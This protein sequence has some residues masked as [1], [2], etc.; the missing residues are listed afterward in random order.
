MALQ[1]LFGVLR[2]LWAAFVL[3]GALVA[4]GGGGGGGG[5]PP[6]ND[7]PPSGGA[8]LTLSVAV[9]GQGSVSS[10]TSGISCP[11]TCNAEFAQGSTVQLTATAAANQRF[12]GWG[13]ACSGTQSTCAVL[14]S[15]AR[16]V[17]AAFAPNDSSSFALNVSVSGQGSVASQP[18]GINCGATCS[19]LFAANTQVTLTATPASGQVFSAWTG[20]CAGSGAVCTLSLSADRVASAVFVA[21]AAVGWGPQTLVSQPGVGGLGTNRTAM[22][23]DG[24]AMTTW[25]ESVIVQNAVVDRALWFSRYTPGSGWTAP[26]EVTRL[27]INFDDNPAFALSAN[28]EAIY[29]WRHFLPT[30]VP[31]SVFAV[32]YSPSTGWS[33]TRTV[34]SIDSP[35]FELKAGLDDSGRGFVMWSQFQLAPKQFELGIWA[36]R[37]GNGSWGTAQLLNTTNPAADAVVN[38]AVMPGGD[39]LGVWNGSGAAGSGYQSAFFSQGS[40]SWGEPVRIVPNTSTDTIFI[41]PNRPGLAASEAGAVLAWA[42]GDLEGSGLPIIYRSQILSLRFSNGAWATTP[43]P[44]SNP[45]VKSLSGQEASNINT[46]RPSVSINA[47]GVAAVG[48]RSWEDN[49]NAVWVNRS[50]AGGSWQTPQTI[51]GGQNGRPE[52]VQLGIASSGNV[53]AAWYQSSGVTDTNVFTSRLSAAGWSAPEAMMDYDP[54]RGLLAHYVLATNARGDAVLTYALAID[55]LRVGSQILSR[56]FV[57][58]P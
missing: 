50:G 32:S 27:G 39:A 30:N 8:P 51:N 57:A 42:Q 41:F 15:E 54:S 47:Q 5:T 6:A 1:R 35:V 49:T 53:M 31:H 19:A 23:P 34:N 45:V 58:A 33:G 38:L 55:A 29:A 13:G 14:M 2:P 7:P 40:L 4:C 12:T 28:G 22:A 20:D 18:A 24:S 16:N 36:N 21:P 43:V 17:T 3:A 44:I 52:L 25:V 9:V 11:S 46:S 56:Y 10:N 37:F 48:W 26:T